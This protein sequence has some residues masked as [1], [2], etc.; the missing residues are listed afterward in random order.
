[1][2]HRAKLIRSMAYILMACAWPLGGCTP[3]DQA[4]RLKIEAKT[5]Q[6][7]PISGA[8][9]SLDGKPVGET[10]LSG[11]FVTDQTIPTGTKPRLEVK[12]DS[13]TY[14]F[15]PYYESFAVNE[16][17]AAGDESVVLEK[18]FK[19]TLYFVPK[20]KPGDMTAEE[21]VKVQVVVAPVPAEA[22]S[23]LDVATE[24]AESSIN[25]TEVPNT[26][27]AIASRPRVMKAPSLK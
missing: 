3:K 27:N 4:V 18:E 21:P 2:K 6:G 15:A 19:A 13:D 17:T 10:D 5:N 20:P 22:P 7:E 8:V 12:K 25:V 23:A 1:M 16:G 11:H 24:T 9:V 26:R 14:Y